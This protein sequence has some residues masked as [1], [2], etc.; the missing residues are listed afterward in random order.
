[1]PYFSS[2]F[3]TYLAIDLVIRRFPNFREGK[4]V[5]K[6]QTGRHLVP[7]KDHPY[8]VSILG[9]EF[10]W[11]GVRLIRFLLGMCRGEQA[12]TVLILT[13]YGT[14]CHSQPPY[15]CLLAGIDFGASDVISL[16]RSIEATQ[17]T[18]LVVV[19]WPR[20]W[21]LSPQ[22]PYKSQESSCLPT[23]S[24]LMPDLRLKTLSESW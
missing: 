22:R 14:A 16:M 13:R 11:D 8:E 18:V 1:M 20:S 3:G 5:R 9:S 6:A 15:T 2:R 10:S 21:L 17:M 12:L 24:T 7:M 4:P 19:L 23:T